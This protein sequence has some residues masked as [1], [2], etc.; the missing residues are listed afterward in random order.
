[1]AE[2]HIKPNEEEKQKE[3]FSTNPKGNS[4]VA[5]LPGGDIKLKGG[6]RFDFPSSG[7]SKPE[8]LK[9]FE[10]IKNNI[11]THLSKLNNSDLTSRNEVIRHVGESIQDISNI[12]SKP[13]IHHK[14]LHE[15]LR[16]I[17]QSI[18]KIQRS[19]LT[20]GY[21]L[22]VLEKYVSNIIDVMGSNRDTTALLSSVSFDSEKYLETHTMNVMM[23]CISTAIQLSKIMKQKLLA[24]DVGSHLQKVVSCGKKI[25]TR[26][27]LIN[28]GI[29]ALLHDIHLQGKFPNLHKSAKLTLKDQSE[30]EKHPSAGYHLLKSDFGDLD[31]EIKRAVYQHHE[32]IDGSGHPNGVNVNLFS[33][34]S[35]ILSFAVYYVMRITENPFHPLKHP[36]IALYQILS[37]ERN[38]FDSDVLLAY[39]RA[40]SL[41]PIGCWVLLNTGELGIV[42]KGHPDQPKLPVVKAFL[43]SKFEPIN[44]HLVDTSASEIKI[45]AP[46]P[47]LEV[48]KRVPNYLELLT[49]EN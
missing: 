26:Q 45:K 1:M 27:E 17:G 42:C 18:S 44:T 25:F 7:F 10:A 11:I 20:K 13:P 36:H 3:P 12:E 37:S 33:R 8:E 19:V 48:K 16:S 39:V 15:S 30:I 47:F 46:V 4:Q 24:Q 5:N 28:L 29:A 6:K 32:Y 9:F 21:S 40:A 43:N 14:Q 38:K 2:P 41:Y 31:F 49:N 35:L 34:Y 22:D 23:V